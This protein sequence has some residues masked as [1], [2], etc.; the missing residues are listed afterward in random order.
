[1]QPIQA[2]ITPNSPATLVAQLQDA[3]TL[4]LERDVYRFDVD[5]RARFLTGL[6]GE[7][8]RFSDFTQ[9][10]VG[11][12][13]EQHQL[14]VTGAVDEATAK[15]LNAVL[16]ELGALDPEN[17][18]TG[19]VK[20]LDAQ[21]RTLNAINTG[22]DRLI[23]IDDKLSALGRSPELALNMRGD[24]VSALQTQL[25]QIGVDLPAS[26][27]DARLFGAGTQEALRQLQQ[28][29]DLAQ[30]GRLDDG[31]RAIL[32]TLAAGVS[33][34]RRVEGRILLDN[35]LPA[36]GVRLRVVHRGFGEA[37]TALGEVETD[38]RGYYALTYGN[39]ATAANLEVQA[40]D[41]AGTSV[42][43]SSPIVDADRSTVLNL[44]APTTVKA[45]TSEYG[46]LT[47][48]LA[49]SVGDDLTRLAQTREDDTRQD[50]TLLHEASG[51]DAR[52][53]TLA[54]QAARTSTETGLSQAALYGALRSGLPADATALADVSEE[55]FAAALSHASA[56]GIVALDGP[57]R[58]AAQK[59]FGDF[60]RATLR[61]LKAPGALSSVGDLLDTATTVD[62]LHRTTFER[63]ALAHAD[64][65]PR[66]LWD[67][68]RAEGIPDD[69]IAQLQLQG[70]LAYLTLNN[71]PLAADLQQT[72]QSPDKL[73][74]LVDQDLYDA[75]GWA[76]RLETLASANGVVDADRL[77]GLIPPAYTQPDLPAR[78]NAYSEDMARQ[79][80]QAYPTRVVSRRIETDALKL[81]AQHAELKTP[82]QTF[83]RTAAGAG[84]QLGRV[85]VA[86]YLN[87]QG[88]AAFAG[89]TAEQ[90]PLAEEGVRLL[91]RVYQM[92]PNDESMSVLLDLGFT[93]AWQVAAIAKTEFVD[94]YWERFGS[95]T[96]A[97][98]VWEKSSQI[99]S[100]T[101][102]VFTL[103]KKIESTPPVLALSG[104]P[105]QFN[106]AKENLGLLL[107]DYPT[108]ES[109]F[110]S[111]DFCDCE[112][113]RS[114][115]SPAAYLV[116]LLRFV[117]PAEPV[118]AQALI[119]WKN[120]HAGKAYDG[121]E[122]NFLK[123]YDALV[124]RRPDLPNLALTC[125]NT[126]TVLPYID[127]VNEILEY[128]VANGKIDAA[129]ARDTGPA[130]SAELAAEPQNLLPAAYDA[131]RQA[132]HP[133]TLPFDLWLETAR[134][135]CDHFEVPFWRVLEVFRPQAVLFPPTADPTDYARAQVWLEQLGL[136]SDEATLLTDPIFAE[137]PRLFGFDTETDVQALARL[138]SAK[139]LADRLGVTYRELVDLVQ[140]DFIN[141][142]LN[143]LRLLQTL[144]LTVADVVA[145]KTGT[146]SAEDKAGFEQRLA[147]IT[148]AYQATV[149]GFDA[150]TWVNDAWTNG[151][152][153]QALLLRDA[154]AGCT[155]E[156]TEL[157]RGDGGALTALDV[158]RFNLFV[159]LW[160]RLGWSMAE[161]DQALRV[162]LPGAIAP[163][164]TTLGPA[165]QTAL[166]NLAHLKEL[167]ALLPLGRNGR[168][169]LT[170]LWV[171]L[172]TRGRQSLYAQLFLTRAIL[173]D[174]PIF[175]HPLGQY[176]RA[177]GIALKAHASAVQAAL[178][179]TADEA[180]LILADGNTGDEA[181]SAKA[182][183]SL[184]NVSL[185]YRYRFLAK[186]L[187]V[188][189]AE[190]I[191]LKTLSGLDPF[192]PLHTGLLTS[193]EDDH[194]FGQTL[195]FVR[196]VQAVKSGQ[197]AVA[198]LTYLFSHRFDPAGPYRLDAAGP[199]DALRALATTLRALDADFAVPANALDLTDEAL[200]TKMLLVFA[201]DVVEDFMG[202]WTDQAVYS[203][204]AAP[205]VPA[206]RLLPAV[207]ALSAISLAYDE[208]RQRQQVSHQG[209][210]T[211]PARA[212]LLAQAALPD[213]GDADAV[214]ARQTFS[215]L[216]DAVVA[217]STTQFKVF[218]D[219]HFDGLLKFDDFFGAGVVATPEEKR[220]GLLKVILPFLHRR[221]ATQA[222]VATVSGAIGADP[223]LLTALLTEPAI[224][225][226][227]DQNTLP[228]VVGLSALGQ[229]G[230]SA[231][232]FA[233]P[234]FGGAAQAAIT[235]SV[236]VTAGAANS[237]RWRANVEVPVAGA[238]RFYAR[239]AR[240][241]ATV[242]VQCT[243]QPD[244]VLTGTAAGANAELSGFVELQPGQA[245]A[246]TIEADNLQ[247]GAFELT[248]KG[249]TTARV[250]LEQAPFATVPQT[251]F[252]DALRAVRLASKA[253]RL[254][255]A[256]G[257]SPRELRHILTHGADF[258]GAD[259]RLLPTEADDTQA[260]ALWR[261]YQ[262]LLAYRTL[263]QAWS[264]DTDDLIGVFESARRAPAP[265][266]PALAEQLAALTRRPQAT[267]IDTA[268]ALRL[269][270]AAALADVG[271]V[272]RLWQALQILET[273]GVRMEALKGWLT[274]RPDAGVAR[275]IRDAIKARYEPAAWLQIAKSIFD[276]L[277]AKRRDALVAHILHQTPEL[278]SIE[279]LFEYFLIDPG[280]EP[281]VQ[282]SRLRLAISALQTFIQRCFLNL[283]PR[284]HPS[285][286]AARHWSWMKRYRVWEANR[287]IFLYP[288]NWLEPEWR[289]DK[290]HLYQE[291]ESK[292]LQGD[293]TTELAEDALYGY[294]RKLDQLARL[295]VVTMYAEEKPLAP[296]TLHVIARTYTQPRQYF[297]RRYDHQMWTPWEPITVEIEGDHLAA[298]MWRERLHLFWLTFMERV[299]SNGKP[300][301]TEQGNLGSLPM[302]KLVAAAGSTA[303]GAATRTLDVQLSWSEYF[304]GEWTERESG[305]FGNVITPAQG[306]DPAGIFLSVGKEFDP[307]S[308]ADSAV[309]INLHGLLGV[310]K[311]ILAGQVVKTGLGAMLNVGGGLQGVSIQL[312]ESYFTPA[313]RVVSKNSPPQYTS[314]TQ[315][316]I[317]PYSP[318]A[319]RF[320]T[321]VSNGA[322]AVSFVQKVVTTDGARKAD[323]AASQTILAKGGAF[324]ILPTSNRPTLP[325]AE[326]APLLSPVFYADDV[327]TFFVEPSLTETTVDKWEGYVIPRPS[328]KPK[329]SDFVDQLPDL[330]VVIPPKYY[331]DPFKVHPGDP[332]PEVIDPRALHGF[333]TNPDRMTQSGV[334]VQ[335]GDALISSSGR[336]HDAVS[337]GVTQVVTRVGGAL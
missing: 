283:E 218:F 137:W 51:W 96:V 287:K 224:L 64:D 92:T 139:T 272:S 211:G 78:L 157:A 178:G 207:Y 195:A 150:A 298:V 67:A 216:L 288:E 34:P 221:L 189:V 113:C 311:M 277:R 233:D 228:L 73:E 303:E 215:D 12:F 63:L 326:F 88:E 300:R 239:L 333:K 281:V 121:P 38:A 143:D 1:M 229:G 292:L 240:A 146:Q 85:P 230:W 37:E 220:L 123:P 261:A 165:L 24:A 168:L 297:Y 313:F 291:L 273:F 162:C 35:G 174:D 81:G 289:D 101:F 231:R 27:T 74:Q 262:A 268:A 316:I 295:E 255:Q 241:G 134:R 203:A 260:P 334:V 253:A 98:R 75:A 79:I 109:L 130:T 201:P 330:S 21:S 65:E 226:L 177:P 69:Q 42:R 199:G 304:Q 29:Y 20:A 285:M 11:V 191:D 176:L 321:Y 256:L 237:G 318:S 332:R 9:K 151:A 310:E 161:T 206:R 127:L 10:L 107:K 329:W 16:R 245:I 322:L 275:Q 141:P 44:V 116:D 50:L 159:R 155:F 167:E 319:R 194:A 100:V 89:L 5:R 197:L 87:Q 118:W 307:E 336:V 47:T 269:N 30:T 18:L 190:L 114:V 271:G 179:L 136:S 315:A 294:L 71:A 235:A 196:N 227:P 282:T 117:D 183:L 105:E 213:P 266:V 286:L 40:L 68:A 325:N 337:A 202:F 43:L 247:G 110:G 41:A 296:T 128:Y 14:P 129:A 249:E 198:D 309:W 49:R 184:A 97:E 209:V 135:F 132:R 147:A 148:Q 39:G 108:L 124:L 335:F 317:S 251:L 180:A 61:T 15:S 328:Q 3:L 290:T 279:R 312:G 144:D 54:A 173:K 327:N 8:G 243:T 160:R 164:L 306:F 2:P 242:R 169:A 19:V 263:K 111:L 188:S 28:K 193:L 99:T 32:A 77:A 156:K 293:V 214:A 210:L 115:L 257:L 234:G 119:D 238:Y 58:E 302:S 140:T 250:G 299:E 223:A 192:K 122:F 212:A 112:H 94:R 204:T 6:Q 270:T 131:L 93:S 149:P 181:D 187:K 324:S 267:V 248:V 182:A 90:R 52:L 171:D 217:K 158:L 83:L 36:A 276:P 133:L 104:S 274:V 301:T 23:S 320:N 46:L 106:Q 142:R 200:K 153:A 284:V 13:Q 278:D 166:V 280:M 53:I 126:N 82:V 163:D 222:V 236:T 91:T 308:G 26:E 56:A 31:T 185:L 258:G 22:T 232:F 95:K 186:A 4:L 305:G 76:S 145:F 265:T 62:A 264:P 17:D 66:T 25:A 48:D 152:F 331:Q 72:L 57:A 154:D 120:K 60:K 170:T 259:L 80:R 172:P 244:P 205:I 252:E 55:A 45:L 125:E 102:N 86:Q 138:T 323:P 246:F 59:T 225:A 175:D 219:T 7:R 208:T 70:K 103:A 84:F 254:V 33:Q 314:T